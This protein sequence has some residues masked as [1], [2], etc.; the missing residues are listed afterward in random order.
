MAP[1]VH[2]ETQEHMGLI[3]TSLERWELELQG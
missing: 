3:S 1:H 2:G